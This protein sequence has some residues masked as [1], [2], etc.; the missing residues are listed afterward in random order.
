MKVKKLTA[1]FTFEFD[2]MDHTTEAR[3][4]NFCIEHEMQ[5]ALDGQRLP[6]NV[7][8]L[9]KETGDLAAFEALARHYAAHAFGLE[10]KTGRCACFLFLEEV[11]VDGRAAAQKTYRFFQHEHTADGAWKNT[12]DTLTDKYGNDLPEDG[13]KD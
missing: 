7:R 4:E 5:N 12:V 1:L 8:V 11:A 2:T 9:T 3:F 13:A 10:V 6:R